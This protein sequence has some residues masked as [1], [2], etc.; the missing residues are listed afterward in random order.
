MPGPWYTKLTG[1][2]LKLNVIRGRRIYYIDELHQRYG[3]IVRISPKEI[4]VAD[5]ESVLRI[6]KVNSGFLKTDWY[7]RLNG[8]PRM[9]VFALRSP[10]H[11]SK[12]RKLFA[13][14][15]S[16]SS[17]RAEWE[18]CIRSKVQTAVEGILRECK[19]HGEADILKWWTFLTTDVASHLMFGESF[20]TL[21]KGE[22]CSSAPKIVAQVLTNDRKQS[23]SK[24]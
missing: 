7:E 22:V 17:L 6:H 10:H 8:F 13:R 5:L 21:Q 4:A 24:S 12:R 3:P 20:G 19:L 1:L 15:F 18:A 16:K 11:H 9:G 2:P 14:P 23:T